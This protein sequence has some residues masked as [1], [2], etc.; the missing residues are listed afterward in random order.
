MVPLPWRSAV[1]LLL[2][3]VP[4]FAC[5]ATGRDTE[6]ECSPALL[7]RCQSATGTEGAAA[8]GFDRAV[9]ERG[10][11]RELDDL[12]DAAAH[13]DESRYFAHFAPQ[14]VFLGTDATERWGLDAF[15]A[16]AHPRFAQGKGW[17]F[18][19]QRRAVAFADGGRTAWFDEDLM[20]ER[21]GPARGSGVLQWDHDRWRVAQYNLALTVPNERFEDVHALLGVSAPSDLHTRHQ[22]AYRQATAD[23]AQGHVDQALAR[24]TP[25]VAE[26]K[27]LPADDLEFWL[28]NELTW[29]R[30]SAGDLEGARGE[31]EHARTA[32]DHAL[33]PADKER[34]LRL[35]ERW[36]R[37]YLLVERARGMRGA[38]RAAAMADADRARTA[39][40]EIAK[41]AA[42]HD[43]MA[44]LAAF[45][46]WA[47]GDARVAGA[48]AKKV[49][50]AKDDDLQDVY[51]LAL[52]LDAAGEHDAAAQARSRICAGKDYLMKPILVRAMESAGPR[53]A[54]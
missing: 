11:A 45:F 22:Q 48:E 33:L 34:A 12:H 21:L 49:D 1:T 36:D 42:D 44:V 3:S 18:H 50:L 38:A 35:H 10:V 2:C 19:V 27:S 7:G 23:I 4:L 39:Y 54:P 15:R 25:L 5:G 53:C 43:G 30:W 6:P 17:T 31:V 51:V 14:A 40:E 13:A 46:A 8:P 41:P 32:L 26:A 37:A 20:G 24:L 47:R 9:S 52:A 16:Y 28:D 29:V